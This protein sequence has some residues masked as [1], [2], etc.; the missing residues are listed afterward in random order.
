MTELT[1]SDL[2]GASA[3]YWANYNGIKLQSGVFSFVNHGYQKEP[4]SYRGRRIC[5]IK[6]TG[7]GFTEIEVLKSLHGMRY[8]RY[9]QG[10]LYLMP[11]NDDVKEFSKSRFNPLILANRN[12]IGRFVKD[13]DM[14]SLKKVGDAFLYLRGARL[15]QKSEEGEAES[16]KLRSIQVD[17]V[18]FD[19]IDLMDDEA[20]AKARGRMGHSFIKEE[21]Y[22]SNP[23]QDDFGIDL[24]WQQSDQRHW[25]RQCSCG[26][27]T[28]AELEFPD[29]VKT[30]SS[31]KGYIA[32]KK[33]S[34]PVGIW[35][36]RWIAQKPEIKDF[37]GYR[38]SH[39][40]SVYNDPA[41]VLE[42][43][44]NP[45]EDNLGDV[46]RLELGLPYSSREE[47]LRKSDILACCKSEIMPDRHS[48]PCAAGVDVGRKKHVVI[49]TKIDRERFELIKMVAVDTFNDVHDLFRWFN[50]QSAVIDL[51]PYEDEVRQFQKEERKIKIFLCEYSDTLIAETL[52]NENTKVVKVHRTG[53]FDASHRL[54]TRGYIS[55]PRQN[56]TI[57][58]FARQCCNCAR[59]KEKDKRRGIEVFR[60]RATGS[61]KADHYRNALNYFYLA[62]SGSRISRV[63][64]AFEPQRKL[65][66]DNN[67]ARI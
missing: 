23:T 6:A 9:P 45:P 31:G 24:I 67:Y 60:Y 37:Q 43:F 15:N 55:L 35:P 47:K 63:R 30:D 21:V 17:R 46:Y 27:E 12:L 59:F 64:G 42:H 48:G 51:R 38:W 39:L 40:T 5:Y 10:V 13:T 53:I 36:G 34:K 62:A 1:P 19:E 50:V 25:F 52:W 8:G 33:C 26:E 11:T 18:V 49:G 44:T 22:I 32:C 61:D 4:M 3:A 54:I 7:G 56:P 2:A 57:E 20:I 28:C 14:A 41:V 16:A 29:C 66:A 58:E 65:V